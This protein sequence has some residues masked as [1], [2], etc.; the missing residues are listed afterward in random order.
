MA[1]KSPY[2]EFDFL[3][4]RA[5]SEKK[6]GVGESRHAIAQREKRS[7]VQLAAWNK[8]AN[9]KV[10]GLCYLSPQMIQWPLCQ[11]SRNNRYTVV[12]RI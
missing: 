5:R 10:A 11:K 3:A 8:T 2:C 9:F 1:S 7:L 4:A 6:C 12:I